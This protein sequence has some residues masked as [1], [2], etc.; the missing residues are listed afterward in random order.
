M[1]RLLLGLLFLPVVASAADVGLGLGYDAGGGLRTFISN[2]NGVVGYVPSTRYPTLDLAIDRV[3]I[4][5]H[6]VDTV[7]AAASEDG[8]DFL[9]GTNV[10]VRA[11]DRPITG[12]L[13]ATLEPGLSF[14]M[15]TGPAGSID[16]LLGVR[17]GVRL[18]SPGRAVGWAGLYLVPAMGMTVPNRAKVQFAA[19]LGVELTAGVYLGRRRRPEPTEASA[20]PVRDDA[21]PGD[22]NSP[23]P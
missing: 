2:Q 10:W 23:Q 6:L 12:A 7:A 13:S 21:T 20:A 4:Q 22:D 3:T 17:A 16:A 19:A 9:F 18:A 5:V 8:G 14:D 15:M 11:I 1:R